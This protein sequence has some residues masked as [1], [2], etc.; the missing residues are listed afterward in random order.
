MGRIDEFVGKNIAVDTA[1]VIYYIEDTGPYAD[2]MDQFFNR[3]AAGEYKAS[4]SVITLLEVLVQPFRQQDDS[5]EAAYRDILVNA[6]NFSVFPIT[7][8]IAESAARLRANYNIRTPDALQ[9]ATA[10][11]TNSDIFLTNDKQ[12]KKV[13]EIT[14]LTLPDLLK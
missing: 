11:A 2:A 6:E 12:L 7:S 14:V 8:E 5:L 3:L 1:P 10:L 4:T 9:V 13:A